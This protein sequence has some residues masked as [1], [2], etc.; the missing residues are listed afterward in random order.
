MITTALLAF[1]GFIISFFIG[2]LPE[3]DIIPSS[4]EL[5]FVWIYETAYGFDWLVPVGTLFSVFGA[6]LVVETS[7]FTWFG[8]NWLIQRIRG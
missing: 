8:V 5:A 7:L 4:V 1:L 3:A 6:V 2:L